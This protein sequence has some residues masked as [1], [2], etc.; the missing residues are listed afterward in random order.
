MDTMLTTPLLQVLYE[1]SFASW[2]Y[3]A[4]QQGKATEKG[5]SKQDIEGYLTIRPMRRSRMGYWSVA[6]EGKGSN[7]FSITQLIGQKKQ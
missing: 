5:E 7:C 6:L 3:K 2:I 4:V 1:F